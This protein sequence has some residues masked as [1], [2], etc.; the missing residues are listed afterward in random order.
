MAGVALIARQLGHNVTGCDKDVYP[1]IST[2]LADQGIDV[3]QGYMP[4]DLPIDADIMVIG[5]AM[6]RGN[7]AVEHILNHKIPF[8]SG[9]EWLKNHVLQQRRVIAVAG[10]HGKTTTTSMICHILNDNGI[11]CG[12]LVGGVPG[13]FDVSARAGDDDYFVIEADEYDS[14]FFD[15]RSKFVHYLPDIL[16]LNNLEFDHGD[17]FTDLDQIKTQFHHLIRTLPG[18]GKIISNGSD[19]HLRLMLEMG[20]WT[21]VEYFNDQKGAIQIEDHPEDY[22]RCTITIGED[23]E[24]LQWPIF[25]KHNID[26]ACAA[27]LAAISTGLSLKQ[28]VSALAT[29]CLPKRRLQRL[30]AP[31]G[32]VVYEDFAHHPTAIK[33]TIESLQAR[34]QPERLILAL[35]PRSNTM[36]MG[37][38][39]ESLAA[40]IQQVSLCFILCPEDWNKTGIDD[41]QTSNVYLFESSERFITALL[42]ELKLGDVLV[43]MSNGS[44]MGVPAKVANALEAGALQIP[45]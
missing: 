36:R 23:T 25:G 27:I 1:P 2:L 7:P 5:N 37:V 45:G 13:N 19:E 10:T 32:I 35:E 8:T 6:S 14:A 26:N 44:F 31:D 24:I 20:C 41:D 16:I 40:I 43:F 15:K 9:P 28:A 18:N 22:S 21:P 30:K 42:T 12:F 33:L 39:N 11:R 34:Y 4:E 29:F 17:I 38:H 3:I